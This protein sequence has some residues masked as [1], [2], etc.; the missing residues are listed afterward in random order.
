M[1]QRE[2]VLTHLQKYGKI[3]S[4]TAFT[5]YHITRLSSIIFDLR[6]E[7]HNISTVQKKN[8]THNYGD[9]VLND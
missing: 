3:D 6:N 7:G 5:K 2:K 9:Y 1:T 4:A 8:V